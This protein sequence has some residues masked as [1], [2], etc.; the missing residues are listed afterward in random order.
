M[1]WLVMGTCA[2]EDVFLFGQL[3]LT[4]LS[5]SSVCDRARCGALSKPSLLTLLAALSSCALLLLLCSRFPHRPPWQPSRVV[6][7]FQPHV[8]GLM[9]HPVP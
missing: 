2:L 9:V 6:F 3:M 1:P 5:F 4:V 8:D 7:L